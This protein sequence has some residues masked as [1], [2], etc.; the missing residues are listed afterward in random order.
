MASL[1]IDLA[2]NLSFYTVPAAFLLCLLPQAVV[3]S[4]ARG[5]FDSA[6]P[7][8][9]VSSIEQCETLKKET[10]QTFIRAKCASDNGFETIGVF[11]A[12]VVA[13]NH[14]GVETSALNTLSI[15]YV[16]SRLGYIFAYVILG[17]NRK[18]APIRTLTWAAG[19]GAIFILFTRAASR[20]YL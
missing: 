2:K 20:V 17:A 9:F 14:A 5:L 15:F 1:G 4:R 7:R 11:A 16:I 10:K 13:A 8:Q 18:L 3:M 6:Y 12:A 19:I